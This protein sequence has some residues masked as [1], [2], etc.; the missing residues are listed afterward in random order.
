M[1]QRAAIELGDDLNRHLE[2][3]PHT[4]HDVG[5][6]NGSDEIAAERNKR[7]YAAVAHSFAGS[8]RVEATLARG[9][10]AVLLREALE[11]NELGLFRDSDRALALD[12]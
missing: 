2:L 10:K 9:V 5:I 1:D 12:I 8:H 6:G 7:L 3:P 4:F 11:R